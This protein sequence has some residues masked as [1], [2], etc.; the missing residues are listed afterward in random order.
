MV[1]VRDP[2]DKLLEK[3]AS[4]WK[5]CMKASNNVGLRVEIT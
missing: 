1:K 2:F 5:K 3:E 4:P